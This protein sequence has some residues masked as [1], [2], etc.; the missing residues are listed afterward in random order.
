M[1][2][3]NLQTK[4]AQLS[5]VILLVWLFSS[6]APVHAEPPEP[7]S[8]SSTEITPSVQPM[9]AETPLPML[10]VDLV[11]TGEMEVVFDWSTDRCEDE[12]IPDLA[13]RAFRDSREQVNLIISNPVSSRL[14]GEDLN[15][16]TLDC[17][18]M[19]ESQ[20]DPDPANF[21]DNEWLASTYTLDG[22]TIYALVHNEYQGHTH[23]GQCP[24]NDYFSCWYNSVTQFISIDSGA[25]FGT[26]RDVSDHLVA[27]PPVQY[28]PGQGPYGMRSPSNIIKGPG[29]YYYAFLSYHGFNSNPQQVCLMRTNELT[30]PGSWRFWNGNSFNGQFLNPYIES[31]E[32]PSANICP[33]LAPNEIGSSLYESVSF[34]TYLNRYVLI[35][36]S[37]DQIDGREV[38]GF[39]FSTSADLINWSRRKLIME[40]PLPWTVEFPGSDLSFL[41]PSLLDPDSKSRNF[42][43]SDDQAYLYFTR[44]NFGHASLDRDLV[45]V[46]VQFVHTD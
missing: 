46:P 31:I 1:N 6:C 3:G 37:A 36:I 27:A 2:T 23:T 39:Y 5:K 35:G 41:Y 42:E 30:D 13:V 4:A 12:Q 10:D 24:Q 44:N 11:V 8:N 45:R 22:E 14:T 26:I 17:E 18:Q 43:T 19:M 34:N 9:V 21:R 20:K 33:A 28:Q 25:T 32:K 15:S 38:W 29:D 16:L 7:I 40:V